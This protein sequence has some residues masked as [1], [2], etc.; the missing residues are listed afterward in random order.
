MDDFGFW[1]SMVTNMEKRKREKE[2]RYEGWLERR[3]I[4]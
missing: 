1:Y 2:G 3:N 4:E